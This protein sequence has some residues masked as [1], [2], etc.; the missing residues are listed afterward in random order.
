VIAVA[1][2]KRQVGSMAGDEAAVEAVEALVPEDGIGPDT[3]PE[4][5]ALEALD[6]WIYDLG[7][8]E[9][10]LRKQLRDAK[11]GLAA[12]LEASLAAGR[13]A[14]KKAPAAKKATATKKDEASSATTTRT[15]QTRAKRQ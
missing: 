10:V 9:H 2:S 8:E 15:G 7:D 3:P 5:I 4:K 13:P 1:F 12:D 14:V 11:T 6:R